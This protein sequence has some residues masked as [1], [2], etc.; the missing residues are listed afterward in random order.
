MIS[1]S[2][3]DGTILVLW[4]SLLVVFGES[5]NPHN[6]RNATKFR[7]KGQATVKRIE[8]DEKTNTSQYSSLSAVNTICQ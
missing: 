3:S 5:R 7:E 6:I 1:C 2:K 8:N 4:P